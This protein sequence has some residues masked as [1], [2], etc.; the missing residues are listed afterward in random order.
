MEYKA[1][2]DNVLAKKGTEE[3]TIR[4]GI[5][6]YLDISFTRQEFQNSK[7]SYETFTYNL[8][9]LLKGEIITDKELIKDDFTKD[10]VTRLVN[11]GVISEYHAKKQNK[12]NKLLVVDNDIQKFLTKGFLGNQCKE[13][14]STDHLN[15]YLSDSLLQRHNELKFEESMLKIKEYLKEYTSIVVILSYPQLEFLEKLNVSLNEIGIPWT[16]GYLDGSFMNVVSFNP[17]YTGCFKCLSTQEAVR[18]ENYINFINY[19]KNESQYIQLTRPSEKNINLLLSHIDQLETTQYMNTESI[20]EGKILSIYLPTY[21][22]NIE[23]IQRSSICPVCGEE[24]ANISEQYNI[25][26]ENAIRALL[27]GEK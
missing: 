20:L 11:V 10:I 14:I 16:V 5:W 3:Y 17:N 27:K 25:S 23:D 6:N 4:V 13:I 18:T 22:I 21:E 1:N 24:S 9:K 8:E 7:I 15:S 2:V 19:K 12:K 26:T